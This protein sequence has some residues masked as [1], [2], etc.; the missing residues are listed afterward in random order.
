MFLKAKKPPQSQKTLKSRT[1]PF[2]CRRVGA[3]ELCLGPASAAAASAPPHPLHQE[4]T[5]LWQES[6]NTGW[7]W[8]DWPDHVET[9]CWPQG[10]SGDPSP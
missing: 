5:L 3:G 7:G 10:A 2:G 9:D 6:L 4:L 1:L 8:G